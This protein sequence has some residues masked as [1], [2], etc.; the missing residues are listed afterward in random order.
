MPVDYKKI[1]AVVSQIEKIHGQ[2]SVVKL[3]S[4]KRVPVSVISTGVLSVDVALGVGGFARGRIFEAF[5]EESSGKT[6]LTLQGI[7]QAQKAGGAAFFIDAENALDLKYAEALGVDTK[8]LYVSQPD[9]GEQALEI[10]DQLVQSGLFDIGIIDSVAALV[11]KAELEGDYGDAQMGL[12][13]RLMSQ[14]MRKLTHAVSRTKTCL[15]FINQ[16]R[17]KIGVMYGSP[18]TTTGGKAL[19]FYASQR[20]EVKKSTQI[21]DGDKVIGFESKI[22]IVKNKLSSPFSEAYPRMLFG[23][24]YD[25]AD[26]LLTLADE[27]KITEK[28]GVWWSYKGEHLGQG[29]ENACILLRSNIDLFGKILAETRAKLFPPEEKTEK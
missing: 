12:Q 1:D 9:N 7:A 11:P 14:A 5:G 27:H 15:G 8:N 29:K 6:T 28:S 24:G 10:C 4:A 21:K 16:V 22:R 13:A 17:D 2:N 3:G 20:I 26:D 25:P 23:K 19:K 18:L